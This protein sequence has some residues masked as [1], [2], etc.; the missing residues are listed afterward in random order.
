MPWAGRVG[1]GR[2]WES[3]WSQHC[4]AV[5]LP[6]L[7]ERIV[8]P[9]LRGLCVRVGGTDLTVHNTTTDTQR[10]AGKDRN[11]SPRFIPFLHLFLS[12]EKCV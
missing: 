4:G 8:K 11:S 7:E 6:S 12:I 5:D 1:A 10:T 3:Q 2:D 9:P